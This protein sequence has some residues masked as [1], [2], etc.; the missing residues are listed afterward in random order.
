M[1]RSALD[2]V[3]AQELAALLPAVLD[4]PMDQGQ[5]RHLCSRPKPNSRTFPE[6]FSVSRS[7]GVEGDFEMSR[8]WL[9]LPDGSP[10]PRNQV[11]IMPWLVLDLVWRDRNPLT[12]PGDN[13]AVD[14]N[15]TEDN[16]PV[17]SLLGVGT[18]V[19]RVSD[20]PNDGCVKWKV[21]C[22]RAALDWVAAPDHLA[23]RLR[24]M[25]CSVE[26]DG[27]VHLGDVMRRL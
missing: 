22:G 9:V 17:G 10:D 8:P 11:S 13:I 12:H 21:R 18:A 14:M 16:L 23:L 26:K 19:L 15:L 1:S 25:F 6:R 3:T 5:V 20:E 24:G 27:E 4:A 2:P 7:R